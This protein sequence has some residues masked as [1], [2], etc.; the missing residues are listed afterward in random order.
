VVVVLLVKA[1]PDTAVLPENDESQDEE[2]TA[3]VIEKRLKNILV[4]SLVVVVGIIL[5]ANL[6][7][8]CVNM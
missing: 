8:V 1:A 3:V 6:F 2:Y 7:T 4:R 5:V